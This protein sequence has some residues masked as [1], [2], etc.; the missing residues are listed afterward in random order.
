M[1]K[2][3]S[4]GILKSIIKTYQ[5]VSIWGKILLFVLI[6]LLVIS[7]TKKII[8]TPPKREGFTQSEDFVELI[9][10]GLYDDFYV[11][12]YDHL[13]FSNVK[14]NY[15]VGE[16]LDKTQPT[17]ESRILD[18]GSGTG[19]HVGHLTE[20]G[21][22]ATG[23]D[24]SKAMVDQ[25]KANYPKSEFK[26][27]DATNG[28]LFPP[29]QFTHVLCMYFTLYYIEDKPAFFRNCYQWL[30][31]GGYFI[32]HI[33]DRDNFDPILPP[34]N[35]LLIVSPQKYAKER[36]TE[37]QVAFHD[38]DYTSKFDLDPQTN[39]AY[40]REKFKSKTGDK[41]RKQEHVFYMEP[42]DTIT[43]MIQNAGFILDGR[44]NLLKVHY[45]YQYLYIWQKPT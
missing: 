23:V 11:D 45:D 8:P 32:V 41:I 13:V 10:G 31:P 21:F 24:Q 4:P 30:K 35:P 15:E 44:V 40:F 16:I 29:G 17:T 36:I 22:K 39:R 38:F 28:K 42:E 20:K 9:G 3:T 37:T 2:K 12:I 1:V 18:I 27:G 5:D 26:Q 34:G 6:F 25:A 19:H 7:I 43:A 33:V 14:N